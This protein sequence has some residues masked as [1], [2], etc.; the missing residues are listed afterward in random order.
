MPGDD[1]N[2]A[3]RAAVISLINAIASFFEEIPG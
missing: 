2:F 3:F 1:I